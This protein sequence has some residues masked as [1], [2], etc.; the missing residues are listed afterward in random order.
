[1]T[2]AESMPIRAENRCLYPKDWRQ[3]SLS[4]RV[5]ANNICEM[6]GC[7]AVNGQPHPL[8]GSKVVLTVAH[9][10]HD[11]RNCDPLNL[12]AWC[13]RCHNTYDAPTRAA[14]RRSRLRATTVVG[15]LL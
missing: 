11:P 4:I 2:K 10:D 7:G 3:I 8:T 15:E 5:R 9:L 12:K 13:Q 14:G 1:M 6:E